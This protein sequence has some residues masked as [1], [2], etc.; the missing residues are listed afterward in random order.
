MQ[1]P[2]NEIRSFAIKLLRSPAYLA[3]LETRLLQGNAPEIDHYRYVIFHGAPPRAI[4][5]SPTLKR[6][7]ACLIVEGRAVTMVQHVLLKEAVR[8]HNDALRAYPGAE[9]VA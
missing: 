9:V 7:W 8:A 5:W 4:R 6:W 2:S 1:H 3:A